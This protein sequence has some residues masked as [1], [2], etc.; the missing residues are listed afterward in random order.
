MSFLNR[1]TS[2]LL[3]VSVLPVLIIWLYASV[4]THPLSIETLFNLARGGVTK[5]SYCHPPGP[6]VPRPNVIS[7]SPKFELSDSTF[8]NLPWTSD[9]SYAVKAS[10][11]NVTILEHEYSA[12]GREVGQSLLDT[13]IRIASVTKTFTMLAVLLSADKIKLQDSIT[14]FIPELKKDVYGDITIAALASHTSGLGRYIY[15]GDLAIVPGFQPVAFGLPDIHNTGDQVPTCDPFPGGRVCTR[16]EVLA[17]LN[18]PAY[19][20]RSPNSGPLYSNIGYTLLGMALEAVHKKSPEQIIHEKIIEPLGL[21]KTSF[22]VPTNASIAHLPRSSADGNWFVSG[23]GNYDP[24]GGLWSSPNDVI[25]FLQSILAHDLLSRSETRRWLQPRAFLPSLHQAMGE[26]WEILRPTNF[27]VKTPRPIEVFTKTGG[28]TGYAAYTAIVPEYNIA[29]TINAAGGQVNS[30]V[31]TLFPL[32]VKPLVAYA[33]KL[34]QEKVAVEYAGAYKT[35]TSDTTNHMNLAVDDGPGLVITDLVVNGVPVLRSL[36]S[37]QK[38]PYDSLSARLYPAEPDSSGVGEVW[39]MLID[40]KA[41]QQEFAELQC[42]SWN[43]GDSL[44]YVTK[45]LDTFIFTKDVHGLASIELVG[46]RVKLVKL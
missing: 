39:K 35:A 19:H 23:F 8:K 33:D 45:P 34:A 14:E 38:I 20:P 1:Q 28:V 40:N 5:A 24:T 2:L 43:W 21:S 10:I 32:I 44:R 18:D 17:G 4:G 29:L 9:T 15:V 27:M 16:E 11:G 3:G 26:S 22:S 46:W 7:T 13:I 12:P 31:S 30:A 37:A 36:A 42:L 6:I 41:R 25:K